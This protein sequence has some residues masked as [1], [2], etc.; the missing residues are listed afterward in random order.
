MK[1]LKHNQR[2]AAHLVAIFGVVLLAV[3]GFTGYRVMHNS[4]NNQTASTTTTT[5]NTTVPAKIQNK[6]DVQQAS[7]ALD[8]TSSSTID[9]SQLDA[10]L[11]SLL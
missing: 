3:I 2:G 11:S 8:S 4:K 10:D 9:P 7:K 6:T 5:S 1:Y